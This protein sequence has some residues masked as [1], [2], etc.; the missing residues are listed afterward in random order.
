MDGR[1]APGLDFSGAPE[2]QHVALSVRSRRGCWV[3]HLV[4]CLIVAVAGAFAVTPGAVAANPSGSVARSS[5]PTL[6]PPTP[7]EPGETVAEDAVVRA[8]WF[9]KL[10]LKERS[11][12]LSSRVKR[13]TRSHVEF[14][15]QVPRNAAPSR[16]QARLACGRRLH[17][18]ARVAL[19]S[20]PRT[21][22]VV[23]TKHPG[24]GPIARARKIKMVAVL[25]DPSLGSGGSWPGWGSVLVPGSS[26]QVPGA[27]G[28]MCNGG[29]VTWPCGVN[30]YSNNWS[31]WPYSPDD[32]VG[33]YGS[34]KWQC[35]ELV[36]RFLA[37]VGWNTGPI[38]TP[39]NAQSMY[40]AANSAIWDRHP[41]GGGYRPVP[42]D[43]VVYSG[44]GFGHVA[45]VEWDDGSHVGVLE[46]NVKGEDG[47]GTESFN[48][49]TL[50]AQWRGFSVIGFLHA[51]ANGTP[52]LTYHITADG[53]QVHTGPGTQYP[54]T[55][56]LNTGDPVTIVCQTRSGSSVNGSLIWDEIG[57]G[58]F[59]SDNDV[60]TPNF[61]AF[62]PGVA[63]CQPA[64]GSTWVITSSGAG[65][66]PP[67]AWSNSQFVGSRATLACDVNGDGKADLV[68]VD[69]NS[70]WVMLS[71]GAGFGAPQ[72]WSSGTFYGALTT[73]CGD[74]NG[75]GKADLIAQNGNSVWVELSNGSSFGPP[76]QW[77][78]GTFSGSHENLACDVN[79]DGKTDVIAQNGDSVWVELSNGS[80]F[81][82]P[83]Q[84][85]LG[86]FDG[87]LTTLCGDVNGDGKADLIAQNG[88]SV[89]VELS[90]GS[91]FGPPQQWSLGTFS[92]SLANLA[93][94]V[95]GD[96]KADVIA[97]NGDSVWVELSNGSSF[98]P[99]QQWSL[100]AFAGS[101]ANLTGDVNGDG[102]TDVIAVNYSSGIG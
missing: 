13:A 69:D 58:S 45:I 67:Q 59:V 25:P 31:G 91:S 2:R 34:Y 71:N 99:P 5:R 88:N 6:A 49:N 83:Q 82:P 19:R 40:G 70:V 47:R 37:L 36:E 75:D 50:Q 92:G 76:Q 54:V 73:L 48:G 61:N 98:G 30:V 20:A 21:F 74:V 53:V 11:A 35:V 57:H 4:V 60:S 94:D 16:W 52:P 26:W 43:I 65:F 12:V 102:K 18:F 22:I 23:R 42:G 86:T 55:G 95:N 17:S 78:L 77:S 80:S 41:N 28:R 97:Q 14:I 8:H 85:S 51:R 81:G 46:Q 63:E 44:G 33:A 38:P 79:G 7:L 1:W 24:R 66:S 15:W 64:W 72:Q 39:D 87:A 68:A 93:G 90:N 89:W 10:T 56:Q 9:C 32:D 27:A 3:L 29:S 62:S 96:G 100:G 101:A 84:W